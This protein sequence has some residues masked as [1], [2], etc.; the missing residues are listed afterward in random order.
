MET[1]Y[2]SITSFL[3]DQSSQSLSQRIMTKQL[4]NVW[5]QFC[6]Q[7]RACKLSNLLKQHKINQL[8]KKVFAALKQTD[9]IQIKR[10][11]CQRMTKQFYYF[12]RNSFVRN[13]HFRVLFQSIKMRN[14]TR[15]SFKRLSQNV[16][17]SKKLEVK[18]IG[19]RQQ[20]EV[21]LKQKII[22]IFQQNQQF[23]V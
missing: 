12:W 10:I 1:S 5:L 13:I 15:H 19:M 8:K 2:E 21:N 14:I 22:K 4:F 11:S 23:R 20:L 18:E 6:A 16:S 9:V 17:E 3:S 7:Q